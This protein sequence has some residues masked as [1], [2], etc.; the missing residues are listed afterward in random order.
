MFPISLLRLIRSGQTPLIPLTL[1]S[2]LLLQL[3]ILLQIEVALASFD[4]CY[5]RSA[6]YRDLATTPRAFLDFAGIE[7]GEHVNSSFQILP[8]RE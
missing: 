3:Q 1:L 4:L 2:L 6:V 7:G 5:P 8:E